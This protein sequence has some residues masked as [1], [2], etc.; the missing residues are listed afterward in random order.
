M[1]IY[2]AV[3]FWLGG[4]L[5][6]TVADL[7]MA[8]LPAEA[9][10]HQALEIRQAVRRL[11]EE[12]ALGRVSASEYCQRTIP[13]CEPGL[14][15]SALEHRIIESVALRRSVA[16]LVKRIPARYECWLVVDIPMEWYQEVSHRLKIHSLFSEDRMVFSS[17]MK[18]SRMVPEIFYHLPPNV[19]RPMDRCITVDALSA[20]A[21][22][23]M[24][25]GLASIIYVYP[26]RL[27]LELALQAIF[28]TEADVM[29][30]TSSER[31]RI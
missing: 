14:E 24:R 13:L 3:L 9:N 7:T 17:E 31:V 6:D 28:P 5:T 30:P 21:V 16:E 1:N 2:D 29:H 27:K 26:E 10:S 25:H 4:V 18:L 15:A 22:E 19:S 20:R 11:A 12:L 8:E 23:S